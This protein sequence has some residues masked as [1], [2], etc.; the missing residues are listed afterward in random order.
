MQDQVRPSTDHTS[1]KYLSAVCVNEI[2]LG[3][4]LH[5]VDCVTYFVF[6]YDTVNSC[7][8]LKTGLQP[9]TVDIYTRYTETFKS[10][11]SC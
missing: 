11:G 10:V 1:S 2:D 9:A 3:D 7:R 4:D 5:T 6:L 8:K